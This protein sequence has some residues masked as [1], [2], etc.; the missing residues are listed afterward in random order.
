M[1]H[2]RLPWS[3]AFINGWIVDPDRKKMSKSKGNVITPEG[4]VQEH[5][6][7]GVRYWACRAAPGADT[8]LDAAQ[9]G[10]GRRLGI[11]HLFALA[12]VTDAHAQDDY[13]AV[14]NRAAGLTRPRSASQAEPAVRSLRSGRTIV[15][16]DR[17]GA[18]RRLTWE[19]EKWTLSGREATLSQ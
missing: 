14:L 5:G 8:I 7:D 3:N 1:E 2:G 9:I 19:C 12:E 11:K 10:N 6:A 17:R 16:A 4:L 18:D 13:E 15:E